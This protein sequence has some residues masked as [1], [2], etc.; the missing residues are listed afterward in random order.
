M[1][2]Y[3]CYATEPFL[4]QRASVRVLCDIKNPLDHVICK[5]N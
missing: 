2:T 1:Y 3:L 4:T 5:S